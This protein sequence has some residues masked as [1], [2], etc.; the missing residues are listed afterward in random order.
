MNTHTAQ[1]H[2][3]TLQTV[4]KSTNMRD[5]LIPTL[6]GIKLKLLNFI[7]EV[8]AHLKLTR[9]QNI[10]FDFFQIWLIKKPKAQDQLFFTLLKL[11]QAL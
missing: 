8:A 2:G 4:K 11:M 9:K 10:L 6:A 1:K 3:H 7:G 5:N